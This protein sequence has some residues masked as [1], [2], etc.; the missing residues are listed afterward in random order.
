MFA[1]QP[2]GAGLEAA[3]LQKAPKKTLSGVVL[4]PLPVPKIDAPWI[5]ISPKE[6][7]L[8]EK[9]EAVGTPLKQ[10]D[11]SIYYGIKTGYNAA[12]IVDAPTKERLCTEDPRSAEVLNPSCAAETSNATTHTG[13]DCG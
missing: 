8:K 3:D 2:K 10:W 11:I 7:A 6:A 12:F 5:I 4:H 13:T 1:K 9:I